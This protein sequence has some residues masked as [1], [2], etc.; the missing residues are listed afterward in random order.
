MADNDAI[1]LTLAHSPDADDM[2]MWWPLTGFVAPDGSMVRPP[3]LD[4]GRFR[5]RP[6]A[7]DVESLN[8][9][10]DQR[11]L[12]V[13]AVSAAAWPAVAGRYAITEAGASFGEGYGPRVVVAEGSAL[14]CEGC[15][16]AAA[17]AGRELVVAIP[18]ERTT[19]AL[20][21]RLLLGGGARGGAGGGVRLVAMPFQR[22]AA[23]VSAGEADAGVLI[24]EAQ[25][26]H[27][28]DG[29]RA[30]VD[31]GRWWADTEGGPLPLGLNV[32]RRSLEEEHGTGTL[33]AV[34]ELLAAS[35]DHARAH[36]ADTRAYLEL[37]ADARPEWRTPGLLDR[38]LTMYVSELTARMG[39]AGRHA[40]ERLYDRA[41][42]AGLLDRP[43]T[44]EVV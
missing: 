18:G 38:Y 27:E 4:T 29:L 8:A 25:L 39:Q 15:L 32:V 40:L 31:L 7:E 3:T 36:T 33:A 42:A 11:A 28:A 43:P 24:H 12:D 20:V 44:V 10:A 34:S 9:Q 19:A 6:L 14:R 1:E 22:V 5:F 23:A 21:L 16:R 41:H 30:I 35:V 37:H 2:A 26:T 17:D 13:T